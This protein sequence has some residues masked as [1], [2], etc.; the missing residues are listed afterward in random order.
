MSDR[1]RVDEEGGPGRE[2]ERGPGR[3]V[4]PGE[5]DTVLGIAVVTISSDRTLETD[6]P[7]AE[8]VRVVED[9][10]HE[11]ETRERIEKTHDKVQ[12]TISRMVDRGDVD[13]VVTA[14]GTGVEPSDET[15]EAVRPLLDK[16]L[17]AFGE[18][19]THLAY[20][21]I[22]TRVVGGRTQ[23]GI[24]DGVPVFCLPGNADATRLAVERIVVPE[25]VSLV[26]TATGE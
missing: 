20:E 3:D 2:A 5:V 12:A 8:V 13:V 24:V 14:G 26:G 6:E 1:A 10:G 25:A 17:P 19:F 21:R 11:V 22:G 18:V 15:I 16:D 4:D 7:S 23:A 9:A